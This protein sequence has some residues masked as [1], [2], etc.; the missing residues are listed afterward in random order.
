MH[1]HVGRYC[2]KVLWLPALLLIGSFSFSPRRGQTFFASAN[3]P[4]KLTNHGVPFDPVNIHTSRRHPVLIVRPGTDQKLELV[5]EGVK[6]LREQAMPVAVVVVIGPYRSGEKFL[7]KP[8]AWRWLRGR[9][10]GRAPEAR[11]N[12][13]DMD[14]ERATSCSRTRHRVC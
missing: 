8:V 6:L 10:W 14:V 7:T 2:R 5:S 11:G 1:I 12:E 9:I 13:G 4:E 3:V